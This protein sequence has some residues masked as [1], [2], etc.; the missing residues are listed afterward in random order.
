M[1]I[2][3]FLPTTMKIVLLLL[4]S[5]LASALAFVHTVGPSGEYEECLRAC[6][7]AFDNVFW[8]VGVQILTKRL[9]DPA[10]NIK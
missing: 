10:K 2:G 5:L 1:D 3:F 4:V 7:P 6:Y 8:Y 9:G